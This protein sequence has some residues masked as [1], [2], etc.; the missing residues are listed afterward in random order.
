MSIW[1]KCRWSAVGLLAGSLCIAQAWLAP[2]KEKAPPTGAEK[3]AE[4]K[5]AEKADPFA[6]PKGT[7]EELLK[8][9]EGL[10]TA[11]PS[12]DS[13][14]AR[15]EFS[16]KLFQA[17]LEAA[18]RI[19][20]GKPNKDQAKSAAEY[21]V[22]ALNMLDRTGD[23]EAAK[24]LEALPAELEKA[25]LKDLIGEVRG[26]LLQRRLQRARGLKPEE[27]AKLIA[28]IKTFVSES[29]LDESAIQVAMMA[30]MTAEDKDKVQAIQVYNDFGKLLA[31]SEN[32]NVAEMGAM[33]EGAARR[34]DLPGKE[35]TVE[36]TTVDGKPFDWSKYKG[37]VVLIDFFATWCGPCR[38]EM[39]NL[40]KNYEAY[41]EKGFDV[42]TIS[43]D[44]DR[45]AL[46]EY[47]EQNKHPWTVLHDHAAP[48]GNAKTMSAYYGVFGIP[49]LILVGKDGK[50]VSLNTRGEALGKELEKLLGAPDEKKNG[51]KTE[52][53]A[54]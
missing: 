21:K 14:E 42:V 33:M 36:G 3:A 10:K 25:G 53:T 35:M 34:L 31:K 6:V 1:N 41:H 2:G 44:Q 40:E 17:L 28:E 30:A 27:F 52:K 16:K 18:D 19:L 23:P 7:P 38:A 46:D 50:V 29:K 51:E 12:S 4:E 9:I 5:P 49:Q 22:A 32:K 26:M 37:K 8:Y 45:K 43:V 39:P 54:G 47:L 24:K 11:R 48:G 20:A 15:K 13:L